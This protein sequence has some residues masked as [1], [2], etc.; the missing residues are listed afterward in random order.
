MLSPHIGSGPLYSLWDLE[1]F[2]ASPLPHVGSRSQMSEARCESLYIPFPLYKGSGTIKALG[3]E[4][5]YRLLL[6]EQELRETRRFT[7]YC[8]IFFILRTSI[9]GKNSEFFQVLKLT[10]KGIGKR[11]SRKILDL[12]AGGGGNLTRTRKQFL[13]W[14]PVPKGKA[15]LPLKFRAS[16]LAQALG[17]RRTKRR[18]NRHT[19][20][21]FAPY[22]KAL[23]LGKIPNFPSYRLLDLESSELHPPYL[24]TY[25]VGLERAEHR[26]EPGASRCIQ[27]FPYGR[28]LGL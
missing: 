28:A 27:L 25:A 20:L 10:Q 2:R 9:E 15:G 23:G 6:E 21:Y 14:P 12:P 7:E 16:L 19:Y 5:I 8:C 24:Y 13:R 11:R 22:L 18:A 3:L 1:K 17:L 4:N 26:V